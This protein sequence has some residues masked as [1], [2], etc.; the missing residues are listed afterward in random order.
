M[1]DKT[2]NML[3]LVEEINQASIMGLFDSEIDAAISYDR[4]AEEVFGEY[5]Y[6]NF[7]K[8]PARRASKKQFL[9][10]GLL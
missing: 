4:A 7:P 3:G 6:L 8:P 1:P 9:K 10:V 2:A 5:S